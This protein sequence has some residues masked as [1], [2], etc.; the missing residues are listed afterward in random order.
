MPGPD[1]RLDQQVP[2]SANLGAD[3]Q[4]DRFAAGANFGFRQGGLVR[5]S[6]SQTVYLHA[7]RDLDIYVSWKL[8][9]GSQLRLTAVNVLGS[10]FV[11]D[12]SYAT[13][14]GVLR[15]R[16]TNVRRPSVRA[17]FETRF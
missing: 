2:L 9:A 8:D 14:D 7:Q 16:I 6:A 1:N 13:I 4:R 10:D 11:N 3:W 15:N 17:A 5:V 12:S